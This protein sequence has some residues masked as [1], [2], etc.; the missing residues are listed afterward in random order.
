MKRF[1]SSLRFFPLI[2]AYA[3]GLLLLGD[4]MMA[5]V[6]GLGNFFNKITTESSTKYNIVGII[7][8][9]ICFA[10]WKKLSEYLPPTD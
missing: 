9:S 3:F 7:T 2:V 8:G 10:A 1:I 4:I 5:I 6:G